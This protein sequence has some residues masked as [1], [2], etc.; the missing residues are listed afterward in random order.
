[1]R[2]LVSLEGGIGMRTARLRQPYMLQQPQPDVDPK[3][4][5]K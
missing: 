5:L 1:M 2:W 4:V 3:G